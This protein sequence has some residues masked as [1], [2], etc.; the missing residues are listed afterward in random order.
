MLVHTS[1]IVSNTLVFFGF[2]GAGILKVHFRSKP[3]KCNQM[4]S[5]EV[6]P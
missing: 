5:D 1:P 6:M 2:P 4:S 3:G